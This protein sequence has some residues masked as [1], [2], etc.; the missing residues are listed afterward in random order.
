MDKIPKKIVGYGI[1]GPEIP[2]AE[3]PKFPESAARC[4]ECSV[5]AVVEMGGCI[6]CLNCGDAKDAI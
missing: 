4:V 6:V 3:A 2:V 5:K 1:V